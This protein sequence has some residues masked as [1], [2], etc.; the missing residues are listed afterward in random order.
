MQDT[1]SI[2]YNCKLT[3]K[4]HKNDQNHTMSPKRVKSEEIADRKN[5]QH[6]IHQMSTVFMEHSPVCRGGANFLQIRTPVWNTWNSH[7]L[8]QTSAYRLGTVLKNFQ[9]TNPATLENLFISWFITFIFGG[10]NQADG[11]KVSQITRKHVFGI[12]DQVRFK[13]ACSAAETS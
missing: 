1:H 5:H 6:I 13:L 2:L 4:Y 11:E 7:P 12:C 8:F 3:V 9:I 10:A